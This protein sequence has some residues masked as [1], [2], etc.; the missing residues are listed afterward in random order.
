MANTLADMKTRIADEILRSDL[1]NQIALAISDAIKFY[2]K[3]RFYFNES[4]QLTFATVPGQ[5]L[6]TATA[7]PQIP[8]MYQMDGLFITIGSYEYRVKRIGQTQWRL[9]TAPSTTGQPYRYS[10]FNQSLWL[11]P[12]PNIAYQMRM[13]GRYKL[14][15]PANDGEAGNKWMIDAEPLI[16]ARAKMLIWR[17]VDPNPDDKARADIAEAEALQ[18]LTSVAATMLESGQVDPMEF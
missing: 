4:D 8:T 12:T 14:A 15:E 17:D 11:Y 1:T 6:Y 18:S 2:Q 7:Q 3:K 13:A 9:M 10:Y 16:R 5:F